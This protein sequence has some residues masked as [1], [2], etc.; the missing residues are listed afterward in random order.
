MRLVSWTQQSCSWLVV[1]SNQFGP[2]KSKSNTLTPKNQLADMPTTGNFTPDRMELFVVLVQH[3][4]FQFYSLFWSDVKKNARRIKWRKSHSKIEADDE[5]CL[6]MQRKDSW[7]ACLYCIKKP[8]E[9]QIWK[10]ITSQL[11]EWAASKNR[12]TCFGRWLIKVTQSGML[13]RIGLLKSGN[14]MN[15][16]K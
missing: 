10:S 11:M 8:G 13:T 15:R 7:R 5:F 16:W 6:A 12:E 2:Q 1:R 4:P 9:N 14:L 3:Q